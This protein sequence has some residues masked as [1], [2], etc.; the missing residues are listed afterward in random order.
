MKSVLIGHYVEGERVI[1]KVIIAAAGTAGHLHN[2]APSAG[3]FPAEKPAKGKATL[4]PDRG[5]M[6]P[7]P[8]A[9]HSDRAA[10]AP[11][12]AD[13]AARP[14]AHPGP[15]T[16]LRRRQ[17]QQRTPFEIISCS[18]PPDPLTDLLQQGECRCQNKE[19]PRQTCTPRQ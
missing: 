1:M 14:P 8:A 6:N 19:P 13:P 10:R 7:H 15:Q 5:Q 4:R 11:A 16:K 3:S 9:Q 18:K 2:N 12:R 17:A